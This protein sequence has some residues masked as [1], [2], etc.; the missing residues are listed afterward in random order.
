MKRRIGACATAGAGGNANIPM[1]G[2]ANNS[3]NLG[4]STTTERNTPVRVKGLTGVV[5]VSASYAHSLAL[6]SDG[7]VFAWGG[8]RSG[9][10][11]QVGAGL[12]PTT[13]IDI[14]LV[15]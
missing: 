8:N 13:G 2:G 4:D 10:P 5:A 7:A 15:G 11:D 12:K 6:R 9:T 3:G 1:A 14:T